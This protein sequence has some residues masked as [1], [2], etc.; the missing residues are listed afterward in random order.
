MVTFGTDWHLASEYENRTLV[1]R[2][3]RTRV[4][5]GFPSRVRTLAGW[6]LGPT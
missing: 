4:V 6:V 5:M 1:V 2:S 3:Y